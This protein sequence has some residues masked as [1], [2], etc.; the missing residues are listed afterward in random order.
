MRRYYRLWKHF[1]NWYLYV[2]YKFGFV[3]R[4]TLVFETRNGV[5]VCVPRR[6]VQTFKEIFMDECYL[7]GLEKPVLPGGTIIDV[8]AN[9][10]YF[11][12]FAASAFS[13]ASILSYEPIPANYALLS[14]HRDLNPSWRIRCFAAAVAGHVGEIELSFDAGDSFTTSATMMHTDPKA[15]DSLAVP[16]VTLERIFQVN[17]IQECALLKM[18][19]EGA[20][21]DILYGCPPEL[22]RRIDQIA[23]EVHGGEGKEQ[24][25]D[26]LEAFLHKQ[27]YAT[28][29]R[30]VGML[31][32]WRR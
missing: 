1:K 27:G 14:R 6:L 3:K 15:T 12:V 26:A 28:R 11:T 10:G 4:D 30:P 2:A 18:D 24:N 22:F 17:D 19:C 16:C 20:E 31:W 21:Y 25:I 32:A 29:R 8:G 23:M 5:I 7:A 9:A 13:E